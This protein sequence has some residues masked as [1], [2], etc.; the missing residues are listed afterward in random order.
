MGSMSQTSG[1]VES[2]ASHHAATPKKAL[3]EPMEL[4]SQQ[5]PGEIKQESSSKDSDN[6]TNSHRGRGSQT[7]APSSSSP[8][9]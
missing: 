8:L 3:I 7:D 2:D 6:N 9:G 5:V 4:A 1:T